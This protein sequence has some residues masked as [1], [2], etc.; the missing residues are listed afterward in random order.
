MKINSDNTDLSKLKNI[1]LRSF[2]V[3]ETV[4]KDGSIKIIS[5][6]VETID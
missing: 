5:W 2:K 3:L 4:Y 1:K 6:E